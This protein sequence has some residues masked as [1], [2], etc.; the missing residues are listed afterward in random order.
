MITEIKIKNFKSHKDTDLKLTNL[1]VLTGINGSGKSTLIQA[2]LLLRQSFMKS[3]L[4]DG[5]DLNNPLCNIGVGNDAL[6]RFAK[7][8]EMS[9]N[10][11]DE[12]DKNYL[13]SFNLDER[14]LNDSFLPKKFYSEDVTNDNLIKLALFNNNFQYISALRW[15]AKS[16]FPKDTYA[17]E[18][19]KQLSLNNGQGELVAHYLYKFGSTEAL[20]YSKGE[21]SDLSLMSQTVYWEQKISPHVTVHVETGKDNNSYAITYGYEGNENQRPIQ[22][23]KAENVGFGISYT[24]PLLVA[25]LSAKPGSLVIIE[26]PEAHLHPDG[27]AELAKLITMV[28]QNGIQ[29][30]V[31]TH[32]DHII[33]G[34]QLACKAYSKGDCFGIDKKNVSIYYFSNDLV[35]NLK[36]DDLSLEDTGF[37]VYQPKGFFDRSESDMDKLYGE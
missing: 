1:T 8:G 11:I 12:E 2:L 25:L 22:E 29:V 20:D 26:N 17:T 13:F 36:I 3:R 35:H 37:F 23:L 5:L 21:L 10:L 15:G 18:T 27:Q 16:I 31:E 34:T 19:Q 32:S 33:T 9:F 24:L 7:E 6:Y 4:F 14:S 28:A 30:I